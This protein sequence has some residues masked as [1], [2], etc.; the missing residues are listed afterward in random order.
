MTTAAR[1]GKGT[2]FTGLLL[3]AIAEVLKISG[4]N[5]SA[6]DVDASSMDSADSFKE[7]IPGFRDGGELNLELN[8]LKANVASFYAA[9]AV[10]DTFT[11]TFPCGSTW[12]FSG[13]LKSINQETPFDAKMTMSGTFKITGKPVFTSA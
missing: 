9:L 10:A 13:Y 8:Y 1:I 12:V 4:P 5:Q 3:A 2:T 7:F 11:L 6:D